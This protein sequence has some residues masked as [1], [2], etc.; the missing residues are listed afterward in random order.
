M[1]KYEFTGKTI[2]VDGRTLK[3]I[4]RLSDRLI[5]GYIESESNLSHYDSCFVYDN[6]CVYGDAC[7]SDNAN[8]YDNASVYGY[9]YVSGNDSVYGNAR[10]FGNAR[11]SGNACV[12]GNATATGRVIT[13]N[14]HKYHITITDNYI[15]I[16]CENHPIE[17]WKKNINKIANEYKYTA[18]ELRALKILLNALLIQRKLG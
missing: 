3:Q 11:V 13:S 18:K 15:A 4:K 9:A 6:A 12:S 7:V 1:K 16:G 5:G 10:V 17:Y 14:A 2:I 8:V